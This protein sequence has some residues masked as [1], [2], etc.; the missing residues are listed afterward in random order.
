MQ[1]SHDNAVH[2]ALRLWAF[3]TLDDKLRLE[4]AES[5]ALR[6]KHA[7]Q[8]LYKPLRVALHHIKDYD[9]DLTKRAI[10]RLMFV[11]PKNLRLCLAVWKNGAVKKHEAKLEGDVAISR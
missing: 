9:S 6:L 7:V 4:K 1:N 2:H 8:K 3:N 11:L 10:R 5:S